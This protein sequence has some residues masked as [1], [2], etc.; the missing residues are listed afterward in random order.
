VCAKNITQI[1]IGQS[2]NGG[3]KFLANDGDG[4]WTVGLI[5]KTSSYTFN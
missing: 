3:A 4:A 5:K 2:S 1:L